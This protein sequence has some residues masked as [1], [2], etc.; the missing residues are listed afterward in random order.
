MRIA[1]IRN[2]PLSGRAKIFI[3]MSISD[4]LKVIEIGDVEE[5]VERRKKD[6]EAG[7]RGTGED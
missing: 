5:N 2:S 6:K 3:K 7:G 1:I 4:F